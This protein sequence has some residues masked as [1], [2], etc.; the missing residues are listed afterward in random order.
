MKNWGVHCIWNSRA[1]QWKWNKL[2]LMWRGDPAERAVLTDAQG[3]HVQ[4][5]TC[6]TREYLFNYFQRFK[7][8][9]NKKKYSP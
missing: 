2:K 8:Q 4:T 7:Q 6:Q 5:K 3:C 1:C 9:K